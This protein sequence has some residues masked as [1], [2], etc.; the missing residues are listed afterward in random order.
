MNTDTIAPALEAGLTALR[1]MG[2]TGTPRREAETFAVAILNAWMASGLTA[3]DWDK[4]GLRWWAVD[5][6]AALLDGYAAGLAVAAREAIGRRLAVQPDAGM[7]DLI[8]AAVRAADLPA[9]AI[10][11]LVGEFSPIRS[12]G[13]AIVYARTELATWHAPMSIH[14]KFLKRHEGRKGGLPP[15][16]YR[17][18]LTESRHFFREAA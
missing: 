6:E 4:A 7:E 14:R 15:G 18:L 13:F 17:A 11:T 9:E 3:A 2:A 12:E 1:D 16:W 8:E 10:V 5:A